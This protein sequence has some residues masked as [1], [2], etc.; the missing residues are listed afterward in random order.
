[1]RIHI[2]TSKNESI[3]PFNYQHM[4]TSRLHH[5]IGRDNKE[6]DAVS[7][8]SFSWLRGGL[9]QKK[10]LHFENGAKFFI[11][12]YNNKLLEKLVFSMQEDPTLDFGMQIEDIVFQPEPEFNDGEDMFYF[13]SPILVKR[14]VDDNEQ[15][16][17]FK[18]Q[19]ASKYLTET[20]RYKLT[21]AG[22]D[23]SGAQVSF[24][25]NYPR[26]RTKVVYYKGIGNRVNLCP[27]TIKGTPEQK[28][29]AWNTGVGNS[30]GI[31]FGAL[32]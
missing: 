30:T 7:L 17:H 9:A 31:G 13:A 5:W 25:E 19:D 16:F 2:T 8:Y 27:I 3:V 18:S 24:V 10:G 14:K 28:K 32:K 15:H 26:A 11:S 4:L 21:Q 20:L 23:G 29:F 12:A 6:H 1:M 22:L